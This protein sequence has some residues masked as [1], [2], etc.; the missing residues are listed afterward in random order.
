M[1]M[2]GA[3]NQQA[4]A[5][6]ISLNAERLR[7]QRELTERLQLENAITR[8]DV[9]RKRE[10]MTRLSVIADAAKSRLM[11]VTSLERE[12]KEDILR[13]IA[14]WPL[15]LKETQ[16]AQTPNESGG[17]KK[18]PK[19]IDARRGPRRQRRKTKAKG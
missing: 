8:G 16:H 19:P 10:L 4:R 9:L 6:I 18:E 12:A 17:G 5:D 14:T 11:A 7:T 13:D 15:A 1:I 3:T 2:R